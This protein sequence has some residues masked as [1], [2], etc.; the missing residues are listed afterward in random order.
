MIYI[1][2]R[3]R[4]VVVEFEIARVVKFPVAA[5]TQGAMLIEQD[6]IHPITTYPWPRRFLEACFLDRFE[7][8]D[9]K[10]SAICTIRKI[11]IKTKVLT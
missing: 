2:V 8:R 1:S 5:R 10:L 7:R 9:G 3:A 6:F 4:R 11:G